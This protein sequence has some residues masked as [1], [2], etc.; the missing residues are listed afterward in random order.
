MRAG[1]NNYM[2]YHDKPIRKTRSATR[3]VAGKSTHLLRS[4][5]SLEDL[6]EQMF[7]AAEFRVQRKRPFVIV[8]YAQSLDGSIATKSK[9]PILLSGQAS[10]QLT[11]DIRASC[12][13]ILVG[14]GTVLADN[15]RLNVRL[16]KGKN[17]QP[18]VLD[19]RLR[20]PLDSHLVRRQDV[21]SWIVKAKGDW[22]EKIKALQDAGATVISCDTDRQGKIDLRALMGL[23]AAREIDSIMVEGGAE[24]ITSFVNE[25]L[26]D[27]FVITLSPKL[28]GGL[29]VIDKRGLGLSSY[30]RLD[31]VVYQP[32]DTDL[33]MWARPAWEQE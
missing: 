11:H 32:L 14:I 25:K 19:T 18:V 17:P 23:L 24:V 27:Q 30:L 29:Q 8:S 28:V 4:I 31:N 1:G 33:I 13:A 9:N 5:L 10:M 15:P 3:S 26:V 21:S 12:D 2:V 20:T 6:R 16:T 7:T 22:R